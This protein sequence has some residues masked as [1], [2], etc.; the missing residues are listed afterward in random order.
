MKINEL[1]T[2]AEIKPYSRQPLNIQ[3]T[4]KILRDNCSQFL[5]HNKYG[6]LFRGSSANR[7]PISIINTTTGTRK[8]E[9]IPNHY[10][11]IMDNSPYYEGWPKRSK[12]LI[13]TT[14][15]EVAESFASQHPNKEGDVF[16]VIPTDNT[17]IA[18]VPDLD[19]W[20]V[21]VEL[22]GMET[23]TMGRLPYLLGRLGLPD[24]SYE[25]MLA[26]AKTTEFLAN[27]KRI[28]PDV[29]IRNHDFMG[30]LEYCLAPKKLEFVLENTRTMITDHY[31][32]N[33]CWFSGECVVMLPELYD[34]V[35]KLL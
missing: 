14:N 20:Q 9:S 35:L 34:E 21:G 4:A 15:P 23:L 29:P 30:F 13:C 32:N 22:P 26:E 16:V 27:L 3:E 24:T 5:K 17:Q 10:T 2:E 31:E 11:L 18:V 1:I 19:I 7:P 12:S 33:E 28:Y 8:S 6:T 25:D